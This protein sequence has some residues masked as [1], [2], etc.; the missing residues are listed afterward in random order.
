MFENSGWH[1]V[2]EHNYSPHHPQ[3]TADMASITE[4]LTTVRIKVSDLVLKIEATED[5]KETQLKQAESYTT[6]SAKLKEQLRDPSM[7]K[8]AMEP[9]EEDVRA[10]KEELSELQAVQDVTND[11]CRPS[12]RALE[13]AGQWIVADAK[14]KRRG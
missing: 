13:T 1:L 6:N 11:V 12:L 14:A 9:I 2:K 8:S 3:S 4:Q 5:E 10:I 7:V